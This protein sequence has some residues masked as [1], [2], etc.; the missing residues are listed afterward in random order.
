MKYIYGLNK[1]GKSIIDYLIKINENFFCWDDDIQIRTNLSKS[2][3]NISLIEPKNLNFKLIKESYITPGI[4]LNDK[5]LNILKEKKINLYRD[6]EIYSRLAK[7]KKIIAITGTNGKSTTAKLISNMLQNC[8]FNNFLGGNIG[9]P[10][11]DFTK[12]DKNKKYHVIELSSFQL[13]SFNSFEPY[14]SVLLNISEDHL[15]RYKNFK[16]YV[17]QKEKIINKNKKGFNI[18]CVDDLFTLQIYN[19]SKNDIIPISKNFLKKGI[20]FKDKNIID[21]YFTPKTTLHL[22]K[23]SSSLFGHFNIENILAAYAVSKIMNIHQDNFRKITENF[24]GLPHRLE[25]IFKNKFLKV[26]NNSKATNVDAALKSIENY[27][28]IYLILGGRAKEKDFTKILNYKHRIKKIFLIGESAKLIERQLNKYIL[29]ENN[30]TLEEAVK[31][32]YQETLSQL[33]HCNILLSP[34]CS[35]FDQYSN[36]EQR[37]LHFNELIKSFLNE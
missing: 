9:V 32:I 2:N 26:I 5:K 18:L 16:D 4:S 11:L 24:V 15:D 29:C 7:N 20:Y 3:K 34:A 33:K 17:F 8:S 6:L 14:I 22:K 19:D 31:Y 30:N 12:Q 35:S 10:L 37:G 28:N 23:L 13:E 21:N 25:I 1:S 36:Y 27:D